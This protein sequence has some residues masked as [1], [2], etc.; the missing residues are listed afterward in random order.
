MYPS[1]TV[2]GVYEC[3]AALAHPG[4]V[5]DEGGRLR[6]RGR[7]ARPSGYFGM[8]IACSAASLHLP[9]EIVRSGTATNVSILPQGQD[10][11]APPPAA[12]CHITSPDTP[13]YLLHKVG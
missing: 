12:L 7:G 5:A 2:M 3:E 8:H 13:V 11:A 6:G 10:S 4:T 1:F 9:L